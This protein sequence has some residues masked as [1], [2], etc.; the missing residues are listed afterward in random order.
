MR[1][2]LA[3]KEPAIN[4]QKLASVSDS[5]ERTQELKEKKIDS[6]PELLL[7]A[8]CLGSVRLSA[9]NFVR[10]PGCCSSGSTF[11]HPL[12]AT[13]GEKLQVEEQRLAFA[14]RKQFFDEAIDI[15][16]LGMAAPGG[17]AFKR[18]QRQ[19]SAFAL[20]PEN[21]VQSARFVPADIGRQLGQ[22]SLHLLDL[23][24]PDS[25]SRECVLHAQSPSVLNSM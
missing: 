6:F 19:E 21:Q 1:G 18:N 16:G 12:L 15:T 20:F 13:A 17:L 5:E 22:G 4:G 11:E 23:L 24:L 9:K 10:R 3:A 8:G 14:G 2:R 7:Q 25:E